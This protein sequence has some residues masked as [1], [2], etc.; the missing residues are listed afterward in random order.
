MKGTMMSKSAGINLAGPV[1]SKTISQGTRGA[2][3]VQDLVTTLL[4]STGEDPLREGLAK[5]P[6]RFEK[7]F[8]E[9]TAGYHISP[10]EAIGEGIFSSEGPGLITVK[11]IEFFSLCEHHIL[12]FWGKASIAYLP[13]EKILGLSKLARIVEVFSRRLQVQERLTREIGEAIQELV[14][15]KAVLVKI[16][17]SHMCMMMRGI[18]KINST[19]ATEH[20]IAGESISDF[21]RSRLYDHCDS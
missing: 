8:R 9:L 1:L 2:S 14:K 13:N 18:R 16:E 17:A 10:A 3:P 7:A 15:P 4:A 5:T 11:D 6:E 20:Y 21:E 19:T 12:P